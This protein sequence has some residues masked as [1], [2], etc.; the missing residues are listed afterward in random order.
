[1]ENAENS[2]RLIYKKI[3]ELVQQQVYY[4]NLGQNAENDIN[5]YFDDIMTI[6]KQ[7]NKYLGYVN[8]AKDRAYKQV[9]YNQLMVANATRDGRR[10]DDMKDYVFL[11]I[12]PP[13]QLKYSKL[14]DAVYNFTHSVNIEWAVYVFEQRGKEEGDYHGF[15]THIL[16]KRNRKPSEVKKAIYRIFMPLVPD[17][18]KIKMWSKDNIVDVKNAYTYMLGQK[19]DEN[20]QE[21]IKNNFNMRQVYNLETIYIVGACPLTC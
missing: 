16:F 8:E 10:S 6:Q 3:D 4:F 12:N 21:S 17:M 11:T 5:P 18:A 2:I 15:H 7:I 19:K 14:V 20:K 9:L 1:M 13:D